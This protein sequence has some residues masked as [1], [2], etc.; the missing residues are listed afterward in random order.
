MNVMAK[1]KK[2]EKEENFYGPPNKKTASPYL[3]NKT[4]NTGP[5]KVESSLPE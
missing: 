4:T 3:R 5:Y 2:V 1:G